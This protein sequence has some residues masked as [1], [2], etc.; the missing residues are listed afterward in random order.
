MSDIETAAIVRWSNEQA[1]VYA[2]VAVSNYYTAKKMVDYFDANDL[3]AAF[4][5]TDGKILDGSEQDG[6]PVMTAEK[7]FRVMDNAR[8]L[9]A[10][11]EADDKAKLKQLL[12]VSVNGGA[13]F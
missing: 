5:E 13:R 11:L 8:A 2:D 10:D 4:K 9:I 1:R 12:G 6:R 3:G 7:A